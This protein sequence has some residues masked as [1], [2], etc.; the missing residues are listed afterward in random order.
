VSINKFVYG[1]LETLIRSIKQTTM[2]VDRF[3]HI[4]RLLRCAFAGQIFV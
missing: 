4:D 2:L 3:H 1:N